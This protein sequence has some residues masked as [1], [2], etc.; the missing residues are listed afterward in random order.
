MKESAH[1][2]ISYIRANFD[3]LGIETDFHKKYD[4]HVHVPDGATPKDG[5]SAG[6]TITTA[7]ISALCQRKVRGNIA[8]TGEITIRGR[9]L[10]I[11]GLKEKSMAAYKHGIDTIIIPE[12][13]YRD[14]HDISAAV[15]SA[16]KFI[17]V[18]DY[19]EVVDL[20]FLQ[21][22]KSGE[23]NIGDEIGIVLENRINTRV[24]AGR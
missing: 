14:L 18:T 8:M 21:T 3:K 6:I 10:P 5:P 19:T 13:N 4:I 23:D 1:A 16:V 7:I 11:G 22:E 20:A 15:K 2:A 17:P 12:G 9:V 24:Y